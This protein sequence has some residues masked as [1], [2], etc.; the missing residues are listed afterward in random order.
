M[1]VLSAAFGDIVTAFISPTITNII[2]TIL[3][4]FF[5][6]KMIMESRQQQEGEENDEMKEV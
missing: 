2:V 1:T 3:F 4:F 5:G 6:I